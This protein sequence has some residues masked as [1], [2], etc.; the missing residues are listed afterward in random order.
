LH[1]WLSGILPEPEKFSNNLRISAAP[2]ISALRN[3][4]RSGTFVKSLPRFRF[5]QQSPII[6]TQIRA[7]VAHFVTLTLAFSHFGKCKIKII[8]TFIDKSVFCTSFLT[9]LQSPPM[10][11]RLHFDQSLTFDQEEKI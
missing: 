6:L 2:V 8:P 10:E 9:M 7:K 4:N 3:K 1:S 11:G 5:A